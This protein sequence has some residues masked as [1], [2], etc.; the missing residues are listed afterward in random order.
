M[1]EEYTIRRFAP[2]DVAEVRTIILRCLHEVNAK[3]YPAEK[4]EE[5][6]ATS[7]SKRS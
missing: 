7:R 3:D 6:A 5:S 2:E 1:N 4:I